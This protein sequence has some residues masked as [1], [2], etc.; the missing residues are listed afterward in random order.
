MGPGV[1]LGTLHRL[2]GR[3]AEM[4]ACKGSITQQDLGSLETYLMSK[5]GL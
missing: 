4:L 2:N 5:Y 1:A 3:I